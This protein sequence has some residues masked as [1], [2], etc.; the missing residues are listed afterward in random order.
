MLKPHNA[1]IL[2][3]VN[4]LLQWFTHTKKNLLYLLQFWLVLEILVFCVDPSFSLV[5]LSLENCHISYK[6]DLLIFD[7]LSFCLPEKLLF[8]HFWTLFHYVQILRNERFFFFPFQHLKQTSWLAWS[9]M[10]LL[11][12]FSLSFLFVKLPLLSGLSRQCQPPLDCPEWSHTSRH[13][14]QSLPPWSTAAQLDPQPLLLEHLLLPLVVWL[15]LP[16]F[17]QLLECSILSHMH[18]IMCPWPQVDPAMGSEGCLPTALPPGLL[19]GFLTFS[20]SPSC[21]FSLHATFVT[22]K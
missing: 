2:D 10:R 9:L 17:R 7:S 5:S 21:V 1:T 14:T 15:R 22:L 3:L 18:R 6:R 8:L 12:W 4:Y 16:P 19:D 11:L 13:L 20:F